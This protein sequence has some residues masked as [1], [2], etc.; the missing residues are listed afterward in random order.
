VATLKRVVLQFPRDS[1]IRYLERVP[2]PGDVITGL[3][4]SQYVASRISR[5]REGYLVICVAADEYRVER[6]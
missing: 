5:D 4:G 6:H 2:V 3:A 1:Q